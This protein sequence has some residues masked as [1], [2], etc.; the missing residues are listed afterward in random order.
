MVN[1]VYGVLAFAVS[2]NIPWK[3]L[4]GT[5]MKYISFISFQYIEVVGLQQRKVLE[6]LYKSQE[7]EI[8]YF[9]KFLSNWWQGTV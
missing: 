5:W 1:F 4:L 6:N 2:G 8:L 9:C 7:W 3:F